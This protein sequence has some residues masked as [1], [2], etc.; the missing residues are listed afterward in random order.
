MQP[1]ARA[2]H[3]SA[4]MLLRFLHQPFRNACV[5]SGFVAVLASNADVLANADMDT[6]RNRYLEWVLGGQEQ[7]YGNTFS[8]KRLQGVIDGAKRVLERVKSIP[9][10]EATPSLYNTLRKGP[11]E[12]ELRYLITEVLPSLSVAYQL[13]G[14]AKLPNPWFRD[15]DVKNVLMKTFDRLHQ[16]GFRQPMQLP[17]KPAQVPNPA[18][19]QALIVDFN[20]RMSGYALATFLMRDELRESGRLERSLATCWEIESHGEKVGDMRAPY[21]EADAVRVVLNLSLPA[22]LAEGNSDR[23][24]FLKAQLHR[25]MQ[26]ESN[27]FDTI[28]PDGLGHHHNGVYPSGYA[29]YAIA[30]TAFAAWLMRDTR[31]AC[32]EETVANVGRGL[33]TLRVLSQKY[34]MHQALSGRFVPG[35]VIQ[36]V[37][38]GYAYLSDL[39]HP[40]QREFQAMLA[41]LADD[42]FMAGTLPQ[43]LFSGARNEVSPGPGA[44]ARFMKILDTA[45]AVGAEPDPQG[46]WSFNYGPMVVHRRD[47]WMVSIKGYSRYWWGFERQLTDARKDPNQENVFGFHDGSASLMIY[48]QGKPWVNALD[49]GYARAGWDWSRVPGTTTRY[50]SAQ[51]LLQMDKL[52]EKYNRP[53]SDSTFA[54]GVNL[55]R[56]YGVFAMDYREATPDQRAN[57]LRAMKTA[58]FF[59]DQIVL[60]TSDIRDGDG[61]HPVTTTLFQTALSKASQATFAQGKEQTTLESEPM[62]FDQGATQ[63]VDAAGNGYFIPA[64]NK[65]VLTRREQT[66][67]DESSNKETKGVFATAWIDHGASPENASGEYVIL[68]RSGENGLTDFAAKAT[69]EY[70]VL[71]RDDTAHIVTHLRLDLTG[72][73][74]EKANTSIGDSLFDQTTA[75]CLIMT[76]R[77]SDDE[78]SLSV[79]NPDL[80]WEK[81][82]QYGASS[83]LVRVDP[84]QPVPTPLTLSLHGSWKLKEGGNDIKFDSSD[85]AC[86]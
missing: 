49:S 69:E 32:S 56:R 53:F 16:R 28:K 59:D 36:E 24:E 79:C 60:L 78:F 37:M 7:S 72:Y 48:A 1:G 58:F 30:E 34:D 40:R 76:R 29:A 66:S 62:I 12:A 20:L 19:D 14:S 70:R 74:V 64:G 8:E 44:I 11:E 85:P 21:L 46:H 38:L 50:L 81:G 77:V 63:L 51:E 18:P 27:A 2:G 68:V 73:A 5:I 4:A 75:P 57:P 42:A 47:D 3:L 23:L 43:R 31:Y 52:G 10:D 83:K 82:S 17:W 54:G 22:A 84:M 55:E 26:P 33:E 15:G 41:R 80:G 39:K 9:L 35:S 61:V 67:L 6:I 71:R 25:S 13:E 86:T 65:V 45:K